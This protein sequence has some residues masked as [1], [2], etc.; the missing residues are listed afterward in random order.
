VL[1]A[2]R[3]QVLSGAGTGDVVL[4]A[5]AIMAQRGML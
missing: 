4:A 1:E 2:A 3:R 5:R